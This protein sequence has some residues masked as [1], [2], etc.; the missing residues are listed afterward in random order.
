MIIGENS[1]E[2]DLVVNVC[3]LKKLTNMRS[4]SADEAIRLIPPR[5][6]TLEL[7]LEYIEDDELLEVTPK[8]LRM[9]KK[10]L[11]HLIR[12]RSNKS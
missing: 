5:R 7:A 2:G 6:F 11:D 3:K 10:I 1:K 8:T 12:K 4:V 9:R